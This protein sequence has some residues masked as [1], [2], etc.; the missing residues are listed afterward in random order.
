MPDFEIRPFRRADREQVTALVNAHAAAVVPGVSASVNEV[1][2][3][4]EREPHEFIVDP[5]VEERR[6]LVAEHHGSIVAAALIHRHRADA[7]VGPGYRNVGDIRW[8]LFR[9]MAPAGNPYWH[10]GRAAGQG[11]MDACLELFRAWGVGRV[12]ADGALPLPGVYGVP[13]QWP[14]V[15]LLYRENGFIA[16]AEQVEIVSMLDVDRLPAPGE[17]PLLGLV[18]RRLVGINGTRLAGYRGDECLGYI[19]VEV[20]DG[21]ERHRRRGG[22]ADVGNLYVTDAYRRRGIASWLLRHAAEWLR[23]GQVDWL[24]YYSAPEE[25]GVA[26]F[27][28]RNGFVEITR[29]RRGWERPPDGATGGE[30]R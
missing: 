27:L 11:I 6:A 17:P 29:T 15:E 2:S 26:E 1:L 25:A 19:E 4:F 3:Q 16:A 21:G 22:L 28:S 13:E 18:V 8:L 30:F 20:L 12:C 5:W 9:P 7:A 24:L 14:H 23:L 10:D